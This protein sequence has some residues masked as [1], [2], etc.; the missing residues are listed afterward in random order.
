MSRGFQARR[1]VLLLPALLMLLSARPV[2]AAERKQPGPTSTLIAKVEE[3]HL[4]KARQG[5]A[6]VAYGD[7]IYVFDGNSTSGAITDVERFNPRTHQVERLYDRF[8]PR[9]YHGAIE[10]EGK[11]YLFGGQGYGLPGQPLEKAVEIYDIAANTVSRGADMPEGR[12][13]MGVARI[14]TRVY[15]IGGSKIDRSR[16]GIV[17]TNETLIYDLRANTWS[18]GKPMGSPREASATVVGNFIMVP[19][20]FRAPQKLDIVEFFNP[21]EDAWKTLPPLGKK[22][23]AYSLAFM[24]SYLF[25][26]G[27]YDDLDSVLAYDLR[28]RTTVK[29][30][31]GFHGARHAAVA[32]NGETIYVIGGNTQSDG[33]VLDL[34]QVFTPVFVP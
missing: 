17:Q 12:S 4:L 31:A 5:A 26:F 24:G 8:L 34:I 28:N 25:L 10:F 27:D 23:S 3:H 15:L 16:G 22:I 19:A 32:V 18:K 33:D 21:A 2:A 7:N 13:Y 1:L 20:G 6:A 11:V 14:G 9:R 30:S 29:V